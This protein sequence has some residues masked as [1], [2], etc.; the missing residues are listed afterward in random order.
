MIIGGSIIIQ[1]SMMNN[2]FNWDYTLHNV[3]SNIIILNIAG[4]IMFLHFL[5]QF[6]HNYPT[7]SINKHQTNVKN[8][9]TVYLLDKL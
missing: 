9:L 8:N 4:K 5:I 6:M 1:K 2:T 7:L 3:D